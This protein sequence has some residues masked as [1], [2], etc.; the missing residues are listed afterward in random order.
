MFQKVK[1]KWNIRKKP[2][3]F[4][5]KRKGNNIKKLTTMDLDDKIT[6]I[7]SKK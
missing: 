6:A 5:V 3:I 4:I 1:M 7:S 2:V